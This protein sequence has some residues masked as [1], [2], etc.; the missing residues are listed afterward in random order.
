MT[1]EHDHNGLLSSLSQPGVVFM[2]SC[3]FFH[4]SVSSCLP[5]V[6]CGFL[7]CLKHVM[8]LPNYLATCYKYLPS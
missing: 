8:V 3:M 7:F 6:L 1:L 5:Y 4:T 2:V